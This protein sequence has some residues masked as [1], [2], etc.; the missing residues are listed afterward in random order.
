[1]ELPNTPISLKRLKTGQTRHWGEQK[2]HVRTDK[3]LPVYSFQTEQ[4]SFSKEYTDEPIAPKKKKARFRYHKKHV[5]DLR[6][7]AVAFRDQT[8][9]GKSLRLLH[10]SCPGLANRSHVL[11]YPDTLALKLLPSATARSSPLTRITFS[12]VVMKSRS[13]SASWMLE[14]NT[15][16]WHMRCGR[17]QKTGTPIISEVDRVC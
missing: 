6:D 1:M 13:F 4:I 8:S 17:S 16:I 10:S 2:T 15:R 3:A 11:Q 9:D 5:V 12:L 7:A 14:A